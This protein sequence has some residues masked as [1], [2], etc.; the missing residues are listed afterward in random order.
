MASKASV[1][2][3]RHHRRVARLATFGNTPTAAGRLPNTLHARDVDHHFGWRAVDR[4]RL[5]AEVTLHVRTECS[6]PGGSDLWSIWQVDGFGRRRPLT[7]VEASSWFEAREK[8]ER[9]FPELERGQVE[10]ERARK[11]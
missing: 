1:F 3:T 10:A 5:E 4:H 6:T 9:L 2:C 11:A 8:G 7:Q